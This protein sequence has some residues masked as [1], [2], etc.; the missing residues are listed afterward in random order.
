MNKE[1]LVRFISKYHL[2]GI[3]ES[4]VLN[5]S[6]DAEKLTTDFVSTDRTLLGSV[7]LDKWDFEEAII[8]IY[9]TKK[10]NGLLSVLDGDIKI[11]ITKSGEKSLSLQLTDNISKINYMLSDPSIIASAPP[12]KEEPEYE[13]DVH[14]TSAVMSKFIAGKGA[15]QDEYN[16]YFTVKTKDDKTYLIINYNSTNLTNRVTIP[17]NTSKFQH[18]EDIAFNAEHFS[19]LLEANKECESSIFSVSSAGLG[20]IKFKV[21][22]FTTIYY[23]VAQND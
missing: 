19:K 8:G 20:K 3:V 16:T 1:K 6:V 23:V 22:D 10:L 9:D 17:V 2:D 7:Q 5:S 4:A 14:L 21:D 11:S 12:I 15:L 18:I 13:L